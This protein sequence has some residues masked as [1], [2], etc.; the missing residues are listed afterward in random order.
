MGE[1]FFCENAISFENLN[2][3]VLK[4]SSPYKSEKAVVMT[5]MMSTE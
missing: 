2:K 4:R 1:H 5:M 3:T